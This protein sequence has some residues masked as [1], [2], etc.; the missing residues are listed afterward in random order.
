[1]A[2]FGKSKPPPLSKIT[3]YTPLI[4][5]IRD[6][7]AEVRANVSAYIDSV[8][9]V[10]KPG[11]AFLYITWRQPHFLRPLLERNGVWTVEVEVL[12]EEGGGGMFEYFGFTCRKGV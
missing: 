4:R 5:I 12:A 10:L 1:M 2:R 9:R 7:P 8:T 3:H 6:P 11:G